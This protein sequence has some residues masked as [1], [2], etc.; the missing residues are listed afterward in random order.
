MA[1]KRVETDFSSIRW[2]R[3]LSMN[4]CP[5]SDRKSDSFSLSLA[6]NELFFEQNISRGRTQWWCGESERGK[7]NAQRWN[8]RR[9]SCVSLKLYV[10]PTLF[11]FFLSNS[12]EMLFLLLSFQ[13]LIIGGQK[14]GSLLRFFA[15]EKNF[16]GRSSFVF[17]EFNYQCGWEAKKNERANQ[18][19][20]YVCL[21]ENVP[22][23]SLLF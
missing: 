6:L 16:H 22:I 7:T 18:L 20:S 14:C 19:I 1:N 10:F 21:F 4:F 5:S 23:F 3:C 8:K 11:G 2:T 17:S 9:Y 12:G 15:W 13:R